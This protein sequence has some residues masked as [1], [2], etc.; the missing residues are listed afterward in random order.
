MGMI[1]ISIKCCYTYFKVRVNVVLK[2]LFSVMG[3][4][5]NEQINLHYYINIDD[6][7]VMFVIPLDLSILKL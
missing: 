4:S 3:G 6:C 1:D 5:V 7:D 2:F